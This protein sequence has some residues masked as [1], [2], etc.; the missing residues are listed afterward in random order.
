MNALT[1]AAHRADALCWTVPVAA[2]LLMGCVKEGAEQPVDYDPQAVVEA[3]LLPGS[4]IS[5]RIT[6]EMPFQEQDTANGI[7]GLVVVVEHA[8]TLDT[9]TDEGAGDYWGDSA[10]AVTASGTYSL[11]FAYNG[12]TVSGTTTIPAAPMGLGLSATTLQIPVLDMSS[13]PPSGGI[14]F[15]D[16]IDVTWQNPEAAYHLVVVECIEADP[17]T[18]ADSDAPVRARFRTEPTTNT[19]AQLSFRDFTYFGTHRVI[20][21][22]LNAD[23]AALYLDN[24]ANSQNLTTPQTNIVNGLGIFTGVN[25]DTLLLEVVEQ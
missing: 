10:H 7:A 11:H 5:V 20:L 22:R 4:P 1:K 21:Y 15:P 16:P 6:R 23:Y 12:R 13:G 18:I 2:V 25:T 24:G 19:E 8:G 9:L 14:T 17:E 3:Y